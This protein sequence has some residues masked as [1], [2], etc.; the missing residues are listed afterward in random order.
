M[1]EHHVVTMQA[2][3][4]TPVNLSGNHWK[5]YVKAAFNLHTGEDSIIGQQPAGRGAEVV[6]K[7]VAHP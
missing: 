3:S 5:T 7:P 1:V 4:L 6:G 2:T